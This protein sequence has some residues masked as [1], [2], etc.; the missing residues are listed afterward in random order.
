MPDQVEGLT[1]LSLYIKL[2]HRVNVGVDML[3]EMLEKSR[4]TAAFM[5]LKMSSF[6]RGFWKRYR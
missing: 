1:A 5:G 3:P 4:D 2:V 6:A